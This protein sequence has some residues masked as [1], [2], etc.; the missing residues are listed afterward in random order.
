MRELTKDEM[1]FVD[2]YLSNVA[3]APREVVEEFVRAENHD[4]FCMEYGHEYYTPLA[5]SWGV[6]YDALAYAR[7]SK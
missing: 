7:G 3:E 1:A 4:K 2:A 6:W 5:D